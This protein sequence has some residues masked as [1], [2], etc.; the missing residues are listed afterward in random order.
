[1]GPGGLRP[2]RQQGKQLS[3]STRADGGTRQPVARSRGSP[4]QR[5]HGPEV[6]NPV[7]LE[8][9]RSARYKDLAGPRGRLDRRERATRAVYPDPD[10]VKELDSLV[11]DGYL[12]DRTHAVEVAIRW[13]LDD[14]RRRPPWSW[15]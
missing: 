15:S 5:G 9:S 1:M 11:E 14:V 8:N 12:A 2:H 10:L 7:S 6:E 3:Y 13:F 4:A